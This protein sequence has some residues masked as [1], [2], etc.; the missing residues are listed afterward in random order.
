MVL[1]VRGDVQWREP[2]TNS[3]AMQPVKK[4]KKTG[5]PKKY[6]DG[7]PNP[8]A[9]AETIKEGKKA[10]EEGRKLP[11]SYFDERQKYGVGGAVVSGALLEGI[12][13]GAG[14][15]L[16]AAGVGAVSELLKKRK[17]KEYKKGGKVKKGKGAKEG[18]KPLNASTIASLKKK[19]KSS[20]KSL[21]TLKKVYRRGQGAY[22]SSGS[23]PKTSMAAWAMGRVNSFITVSK[24]HD[25]DLR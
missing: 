1:L 16:G 7:S 5:L 2:S 13:Q 15:A 24:K 22:L 12:G 21:A 9:R 4:D 17:K 8:A 11:D 3:T 19:A 20:G 6:L 18:R 23:R 14:Q 25:T 10:Y